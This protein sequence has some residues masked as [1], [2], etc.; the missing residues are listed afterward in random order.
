MMPSI[1]YLPPFWTLVEN[2]A[3]ELL[4]YARRLA[5]DDAEDIVQ[6]A[7]L[8]GLRSYPGLKHGDHLRAWLFRI[9]TTTAFDHSGKRREIPVADLSGETFEHSYDDGNFESIIE[10]LSDVNRDAL[11]LRFVDDLAYEDIASKLGCSP[12]AARRR[13]ST[14]IGSLRERLT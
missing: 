5:G 2:H 12:A 8:R 13:V 9:T 6:E 14:A 7:F 10:F 11:R 3:D 1:S 4:R